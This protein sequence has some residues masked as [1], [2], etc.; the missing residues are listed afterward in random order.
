[1]PTLFNRAPFHLSAGPAS[2]GRNRSGGRR[3]V[4]SRPLAPTDQSQEPFLLVLVRAARLL[5]AGV[6]WR[7][8]PAPLCGTPA[9]PRHCSGKLPRR[10]DGGAKA[11]RLVH[12]V[13][14][15]DERQAAPGAPSTPRGRTRT[16]LRVA[17]N[18]VHGADGP[19]VE[20][21]IDYRRTPATLAAL[22]AN[23]RTPPA[24]VA[25]EGVR[26][27]LWHLHQERR[28]RTVRRYG[29]GSV[30]PGP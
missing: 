28:L 8:W 20:M 15:H 2:D 11:V 9:E 6:A 16:G 3:A 30:S 12:A 23:R 7:M 27:S 19:P 24:V 18:Q 21:A 13:A 25:T 4:T 26:A 14:P 10:R 5:R 1:V 17:N 29:P 22:P